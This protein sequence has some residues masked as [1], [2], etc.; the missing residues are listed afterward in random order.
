[1]LAV[2]LALTLIV[3]VIAAIAVVSALRARLGDGRPHVTVVQEDADGVMEV[4]RE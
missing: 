2:T 4:K 1:M 3:V